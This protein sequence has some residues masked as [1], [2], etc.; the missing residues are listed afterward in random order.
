MPE[1]FVSPT[2]MPPRGSI[3]FSWSGFRDGEWIF[4]DFLDG[5]TEF[6]EYPVA[7]YRVGNTASGTVTTLSPWCE[8]TYLAQ[9]RQGTVTS[10]QVSFTVGEAPPEEPKR[11]IVATVFLGEHHV[12]LP[13][14]RKFRDRFLPRLVMDAYYSVSVYVLRKIGRI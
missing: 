9:A 14:M 3:T 11:C 12:F 6:H 7:I 1:F 2:A 13:P 4:I 5:P 8:G 10:N